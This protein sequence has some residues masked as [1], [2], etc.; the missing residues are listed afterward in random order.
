V[1]TFR[2]YFLKFS[3]NNIVSNKIQILV[4]AKRKSIHIV[5]ESLLLSQK[6]RLS[7]QRVVANTRTACDD[8]DEQFSSSC[9]VESEREKGEGNNF[10]AHTMREK[11]LIQW[12]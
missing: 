4:F 6:K 1:K 11:K 3:S 12:P 9:D 10:E 2:K 7:F 5:G 8:D